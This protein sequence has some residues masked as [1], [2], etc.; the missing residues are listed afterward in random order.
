M[1]T[2]IRLSLKLIYIVHRLL[3]G[4]HVSYTTFITIKL[5]FSVFSEYKCIT[6]MVICLSVIINMSIHMLK[7]TNFKC[8]GMG[9]CAN[10]YEIIERV[11]MPQL[12][13]LQEDI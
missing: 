10:K 6:S 4:S 3:F 11:H 5:I 9:K 12:D 1:I 13:I 7:G 2:C 8:T